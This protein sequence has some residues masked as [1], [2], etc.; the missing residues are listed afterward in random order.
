M[1]FCIGLFPL[2]RNDQQLQSECFRLSI[3]TSNFV[4]SILKSGPKVP[5]LPT[6]VVILAPWYHGSQFRHTRGNHGCN[7]PKIGK[8]IFL[9]LLVAVVLSV[10]YGDNVIAP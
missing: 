9:L 2:A 3:L 8:C 1:E 4:R 7:S 5:K 10:R 6:G